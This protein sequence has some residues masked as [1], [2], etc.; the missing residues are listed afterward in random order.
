ML[1]IQMIKIAPLH[2]ILIGSVLLV[3]GVVFPMLMVLKLIPASL[4]LCFLTYALS[5][6]GMFVG[7]IGALT[8]ARNRKRG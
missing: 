3:L 1:V 7:L 5:V 8:Y 4:W 2:M 6:V